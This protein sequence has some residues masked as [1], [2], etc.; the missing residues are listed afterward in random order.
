[1]NARI[2]LS[3]TLV[4][5]A[6]AAPAAETTPASAT[7][8]SSAAE[9][10]L[11]DYYTAN[12]NALRQGVAAAA[13]N[14]YVAG[15]RAVETNR[16][17][18]AVAAFTKAVDLDPTNE[19]YRK[20]LADAV[21]MAGGNRSPVSA[22][23]GGFAETVIA[24]NQRLM[25]EAQR[26]I[27]EGEKA[28][29]DKRYPDAERAFEMARSRLEN[30][31][32]YLDGREPELRRVGTLLAE[33]RSRAEAANRDA[34]SQR[35]RDAR[36]QGEEMRRQALRIERD[37]IDAML[38]RAQRARDRREYDEALILVEQVLKINRA[39]PRASSLEATLRR[40]RHVYLRQLLNDTWEESHRRLS[41]QIRKDLLPQ[42]ELIRY[43]VE[44]PEIDA[45]RKAP[46][47]N[48]L[49]T[50]E[51]WRA[52]L[53]KD[54]EQEVTLDFS[55]TDFNEVV[56][57]LQRVTGVNIVVD[58]GVAAKSTPVTIKV[59]KMTLRNALGFLMVQSGFKYT[60][61]NEVVY[62]ATEA[63]VAGDAILKFYD[64]RDLTHPLRMFPGPS[65]ELPDSETAGGATLLPPVEAPPAQQ[66]PTFVE[67]I[68]RVIAPNTWTGDRA[69]ADIQGQQMSVN[70]TPA[71]HREIENLLRSLRNQ[72]GA[73][74]NVKVRFVEVEN[75]VVEEIGVTWEN[76]TGPNQAAIAAGRL[77]PPAAG[78]TPPTPG[79]PG[80]P[81][82][83]WRPSNQNF[84]TAGSLVTTQLLPYND[85]SG[86]GR[87]GANDGLT[88]GG[89]YWRVANNFY[90][91]ALLH[92]VEQER[93]GNVLF[94]P[95]ITLFS[96]QQAHLVQLNQQAYI[97]D[98]NGNGEAFEP[99]VRT[100]VYGA[101]ID[102]H[103]VASS[104]RK[105]I[106]MT[107]RPTLA[108]IAAW[109]F[110]GG[111]P[112]RTS[113]PGV[114]PPGGAGPGFGG[115]GGGNVGP[116]IGAGP[117]NYPIQIPTLDLQRVQTTVVLPDGGSMI[118]A[119]LTK[120]ST[121]RSSSGVPFLSHIPFLGRLFSTHGRQETELKQL[122]LVTANLILYDE[123]E[124][125]L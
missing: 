96:G 33:T 67:I 34:A 12:G 102:V 8:G 37:R 66:A 103:A 119:G 44:W 99:Q 72:T 76:Y 111:T 114:V 113:L 106:T 20:A 91:R 123:I 61:Q 48:L 82:A 43:S 88:L 115:G 50:T 24:N 16:L 116:G 84:T 74:I 45:R 57:F 81:G 86:L 7:A 22:A 77:N 27:A 97:A 117:V 56:A 10:A 5:M 108:Q 64:I 80:R 53:D 85:T 32:S 28:L 35:N 107:L 29:L 124:K 90:A 15:V 54:L 1:M 83:Y 39:E 51:A 105:Y 100:V 75:S 92:A 110:F 122:I 11:L 69:I 25:V 89:Q 58:P 14:Y 26:L 87:P 70:H 49:D 19:K 3:A 9:R 68:R 47:Y 2:A 93:K 78:G 42:H 17:A 98:F 59:D 60:I 71:V 21:A 18:E 4:A 41:E 23:A 55:E 62:I 38:A 13:E 36:D 95:E 52:K 31:P 101:V 63:G 65:L 109:R 121:G 46:S 94:A 120:S 73:M 112:T 125:K 79:T 30:L 6:L 104:D 118:L 40:E